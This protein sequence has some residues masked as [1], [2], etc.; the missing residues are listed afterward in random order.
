[1]ITQ[2][3]R[4]HEVFS[5]SFCLLGILLVANMAVAQNEHAAA[6]QVASELSGEEEGHLAVVK[7]A[8]TE[9]THSGKIVTTY[10]VE[11]RKN[12][13]L[14]QVTMDASGAVLDE[15]SLIAAEEVA[16][17]ARFGRMEPELAQ[18]VTGNSLEKQGIPVIVWLNEPSYQRPARPDPKK[19]NAFASE[20]DAG[21]FFSEVDTKRAEAVKRAREPMARELRRMGH[22]V[23]TN[24]F[25][26]MLA[27][28]L[29]VQT[30][31]SLSNR[32][33]VSM[34]Y[35]DRVNEPELEI[36]RPTLNATTVH[37]R[38]IT[39][40]GVKLAQIE[41]GGR[42]A[43]S[44]PFL[45][46]VIQDPTYVCSSVDYH[47]TGVAG[48]I[49]STNSTRRGIAYGA[50]LWAGG[51]CGGYDSQLTNRSSAAVSWGARAINLSWGS[52]TNRIL[53]PMDRFYDGIVINNFRTVV[54][55]AGNRGYLDGDVTS[56]GLA[57]NVI[58]VGNFDDKNTT[59]WSGDA[60][61]ASSSW[62]DPKSLKND[63]EKPEVAAPGTNIN[64]TTTGSPWTGPIGTGTSFSAP[65]V[66]GI[67]GLLMQRNTTL[68]VWPEAVR[69]T[70]MASAIHNMEGATRL[71]EKDGAGAVVA[72]RADDIA[73]RYN[74]NWGAMN[75]NCSAAT[76][77][78]LTTNMYL[79]A[80]MRTRVVISWVTD[81]AYTSYNS[82]SRPGADLDL[83]IIRNTTGAT[84]ASSASFD[85]T[86][87]IVDFTPSATGYYTIQ[88]VKSRCSS[89]PKYLGWAWRRGN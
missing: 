50:Q 33:D 49:R 51:S 61:S 27:G 79:Y 85:N 14:F 65:M 63:R 46:G 76:P 10:K 3:R 23:M 11:N 62:G 26:P 78:N 39:A 42:V 86:Y 64:S 56:P 83:R 82:T 18:M 21:V 55:S 57:Y 52:D 16:Q 75:Y 44:N 60:M 25:A 35:L 8:K 43:T 32:S 88:V 31:R 6:L 37:N 47:S 81:P 80:G 22:Q 5:L 20:D 17:T 87:E 74:G 15:E 7:S 19:M 59:S 29:P 36:A 38:G 40:S 48:I 4:S 68:Q 1:M 70:I 84:V 13:K 45:S 30:I 53:G 34:I 9:F 28:T 24:D 71:S 77:L 58:T 72:D 12:G 54:K 73:R 89:S 69:A 2:D 41:V 66:T 67:A